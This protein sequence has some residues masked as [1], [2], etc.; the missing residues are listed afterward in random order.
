[1][2]FV[3]KRT[4]VSKRTEIREEAAAALS[5]LRAVTDRPPCAVVLGEQNSGK[6]SVVNA[7]LSD[8]LLP[9]G[10]IAN[11]YYFALLRYAESARAVA[12]SA[13]GR[14]DAIDGTAP[15]PREALSLMEI[16]LPNA[17][18]MDFEVLD[19]PGGTAPYIALTL[20]HLPRMRI[21]IWC[22]VATQAWKESERRTWMSLDGRLRRHGI[23]VVT[24]MDRISSDRDAERLAAR[25]MHDAAPHFGAVACRIPDDAGPTGGLPDLVTAVTSIAADM[26]ARRKLTVD[27]IAKRIEQLLAV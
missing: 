19:T 15:P 4:D 18:L 1:M 5:R 2:T 12:V 7:L 14:R 26:T 20:S 16:G 11:T 10:V 9:P 6:T 22:T 25:L 8:G 23:L 3:S 27:R 21:P 24:A 13:T 17:R